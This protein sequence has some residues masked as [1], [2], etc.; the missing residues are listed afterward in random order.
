VQHRADG[1]RHDV[2]VFTNLSQ[3][4]LDYHKTMEAYFEAKALLFEPEHAKAGVVN[5]DDP[6]GRRLLDRRSGVP[7]EGFALSDAE[8]LELSTGGSTFVLRGEKVEL[9]LVGLPNVYNALAAAAAASLVGID[10][11]T[12]AGGLS[13]ATVVPGRFEPVPNALEVPV[14][15]DYA[16]TPAGLRSVLEVVRQSAQGRVVVVFGAGGDRDRTK[17]PMMGR[18][19]CELADVVVITSDNPRHED[20]MA[21]IA[22]VRAGCAAPA[23]TLVEPDRRQAIA[24]ALAEAHPGD[25]VVVAGKGHETT[26]QVGDELLS[27]DDRTVVAELAA[28]LA[29]GSEER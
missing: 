7:L 29:G 4:H 16:H 27:F 8:G 20:P 28:L 22:E 26:Q 5:E 9:G 10:P 24:I 19:A 18:V 17:R 23:K 21:I 12:V 15:V 25:V 1:Y 6:Y 2:A 3:D 11:A 14:V 13:A